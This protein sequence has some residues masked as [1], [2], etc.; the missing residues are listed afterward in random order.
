MKFETL[1]V[2]DGEC[3]VMTVTLNRPD[4][5]NAMNTGMMRELRTLFTDLYVD[6]DMARA[7]IVTGSGERGFCPGADLKE[8]DGMSDETWRSQHALVEQIARAMI[9][10][11]QPI[12]AAVNGVAMGGGAEIALCCDFIYAADHA[13]FAFPE[14]T[15]G[16]MPGMMGPQNLPRAVGV[17]RAKEIVLTGKPFSAQEA[18]DWGMVNRVLPLAELMPAAL[19]TA[20]T[21]AENAPIGVRS[22]KAA[23]DKAVELDRATGYD[24]EIV[25]YNATVPT[26][27][28]L[29]GVRAF[30]EKRKPVFKGK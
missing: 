17:R 9:Q 21:V 12:I 23:L 18:A 28:R 11:P 26:E 5:L 16:I 3:G 27:D 4:R 8:R 29:E 15:R 14:V 13:R 2:E 6:A 7:V 20:R 19:E 25:A 22:A 1:Q 30:N 10:A 24:F